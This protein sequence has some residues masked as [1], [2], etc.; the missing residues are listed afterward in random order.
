M[1]RL[2]LLLCVLGVLLAIYA[3]CIEPF[4][5]RTATVTVTTP[6]WP[7]PRPLRIALLSDMHMIW[8]WMTSAHLQN[9]VQATNALQPDVVLLLG[10]YVGTHPFGRQ[11]EAATALEPLK[12]LESRCGVFA[13]LGNHDWH[14]A[15]DWPAALAATGIPVLQNQARAVECGESRFWVAGL[16]DMWWR[17]ADID[18]TLA[19]VT[20]AAP[21]IMM[22]HHPDSFP[23]VPEHVALSVAG[24][25]HGGQIQIPFYGPVATVIPSRYGLRY[26]Y[27]A[28]EESG[29]NLVVTSGLGMTGVPFRL[30]TAPEIM[31]VT[32]RGQPE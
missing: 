1:K 17:H 29:K 8:P 14:P 25:T 12:Q 23:E 31:L 7:Y 10:D 28:V 16:E 9:I 15:G 22:M 3:S 19:M 2:F 18:A 4:R 21:V 5:L 30:L 6:Q 27:G 26:V 13:V 11:L 20:D 24:H 32:L